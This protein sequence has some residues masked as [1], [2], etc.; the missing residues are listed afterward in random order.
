MTVSLIDSSVPIARQ[1]AAADWNSL[2]VSC[3][4]SMQNMLCDVQRM[5]QVTDAQKAASRIAL[6]QYLSTVKNIAKQ[7]KLLLQQMQD[8]PDVGLDC[9]HFV[10]SSAKEEDLLRKLHACTLQ[11][12]AAFVWLQGI[13][14]HQV[15][16]I[17]TITIKVI[18][19]VVT[20]MCYRCASQ[21]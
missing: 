3:T 8:M 20:I 14:G 12:N 21:C 6:R 1:P 11:A 10:A 13:T 15:N 7:R 2:Y 18:V 16:H 9:S 17:I 19:L 4:S 5:L